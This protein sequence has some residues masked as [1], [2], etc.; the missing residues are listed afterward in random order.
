MKSVLIAG[1]IIKQDN[2]ILLVEQ[3]GPAD[4]A[5]SWAIPAGRVYAGELLNEALVREV[6][7]ETGLMVEKIGSIVYT[8]QIVSVDEQSQTLVYVCD[9]V[10]WTG[11][12]RPNDPDDYILQARFMPVSEAADVIEKTQPYAPMR[13]PIV[14]CLRQHTPRGTVWLYRQQDTDTQLIGRLC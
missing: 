5:S 9:A 13:E 12:V 8:N 4:V 14:A 7:E 11:T 6:Y 1:V 3:Q 10:A 2:Q